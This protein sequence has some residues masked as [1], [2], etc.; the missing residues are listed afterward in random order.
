[1]RVTFPHMGNL[2]IIVKTLLE[3]LGLEVIVPPLPNRRSLDVGVRHAPEFACFPLKLNIG[4]FVGALDQGA[5][6]IVMAGGIGP[7]RFGH[8]AQVEAQV[9][10]DLG[11]DV[12]MVILEP[13]RGHLDGL[14]SKIRRLSGGKPLTRVWRAVRFGWEKLVA[15]DEF[16][17]ALTRARPVER[18]AGSAARAHRAAAARLADADGVWATRR[19]GGEGVREILCAAGLEESGRSGEPS[20]GKP[21]PR[22]R[23]GLVGE[24]F[25]VAE[26]FAN[27]EIE[28]R[29]GE[30]GV[31]VLRPLY[32]SD[33]VRTHLIP[34][35]FQPGR[36]RRA[37]EVKRAAQPYLGHFVGG[38]GLDSVGETVLF[39]RQGCDGVIHVAPF[40]CMPEIVAA[41]LLPEAGR[42][43]GLPVLSL[44]LDEHTAEGGLTTRLEAFVDLLG[45]RRAVGGAREEW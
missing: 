14:L 44:F 20:W 35:V 41:S 13:P 42:D 10:H 45:R 18:L 4:D 43:L 24:L 37:S 39:D 23:V 17:R 5:E 1:M 9:L 19:V 16:D 32:L 40:T 27:Q 33:W 8:Y 3:D 2:W 34:R 29:L 36:R 21:F 31:E 6:A 25:M 28:R 26:P 7:C 38:E 15:L 30:M 12:E 11:Y 22:L